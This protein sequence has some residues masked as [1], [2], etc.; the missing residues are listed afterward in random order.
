MAR[1]TQRLMTVEEYLAAGGERHTELVRGVVCVHEPPNFEHGRAATEL[2]ARLH[3]HV[4]RHRLGLVVV[5]SGYVLRRAPDTVRGPDISFIRTDQVAAARAAPSFPSGAPDL[6]VEVLSPGDRKGEIA[7]RVADFF[8][9]GA[10]LVWLVDPRRARITVRYPDGQF[11]TLHAGDVLD[12]E[13]V[14]PGFRCAV[15]EIVPGARG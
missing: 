3:T 10:R 4:K 13:D 12:G 2:A 14:V 1:R 15:E 11:K 5:E 6:A 9:G 8:E 7:R